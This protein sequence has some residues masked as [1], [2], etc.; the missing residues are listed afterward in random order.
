MQ[1]MYVYENHN[2]NSLKKIKKKQQGFHAMV[3]LGKLYKSQQD[4]LY[5]R[6]TIPGQ[7]KRQ[8]YL[9]AGLPIGPLQ[10]FTIKKSQNPEFKSAILFLQAIRSQM[11]CQSLKC[12]YSIKERVVNRYIIQLS[13]EHQ[14]QWTIGWCCHLLEKLPAA[15]T[16]SCFLTYYNI[17]NKSSFSLRNAM[18]FTDPKLS[19]HFCACQKCKLKYCVTCPEWHFRQKVEGQVYKT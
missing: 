14:R 19:C 2:K 7:K 8:H 12:K 9:A 11:S 5:K 18:L 1:A 4:Y 16:Q 6:I 3:S 10:K 17:D 15:C 13:G